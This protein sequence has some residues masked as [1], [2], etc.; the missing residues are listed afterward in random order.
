MATLLD[1]GVAA[2]HRNYDVTSRASNDVE[3]LKNFNKRIFLPKCTIL[4]SYSKIKAGRVFLVH[5]NQQQQYYEINTVF[6]VSI[7]SLNL[8]SEPN[9]V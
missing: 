6:D 3:F 4:P 7:R 8:Q 1:F 9:S 5:P 2:P